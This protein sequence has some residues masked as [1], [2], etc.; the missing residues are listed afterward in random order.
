MEPF[1][2][3]SA[4][5]FH[6]TFWLQLFTASKTGLIA[7]TA[8]GLERESGET[9]CNDYFFLFCSKLSKSSSHNP[10][11]SLGTAS[12]RLYQSGTSEDTYIVPLM[13]INETIAHN[14]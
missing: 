8:L 6:K 5:T 10:L 9:F 2:L 7:S 11:P 13:L 4:K 1:W 3:L 12:K 14:F